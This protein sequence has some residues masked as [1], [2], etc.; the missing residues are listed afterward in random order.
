[1][2]WAGK[3]YGP[4]HLEEAKVIGYVH[5]R[6]GQEFTLVGADGLGRFYKYTESP[7]RCRAV[8]LLTVA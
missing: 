1:M 4:I 6:R 3:E 5:Y 2:G 7:T 8:V